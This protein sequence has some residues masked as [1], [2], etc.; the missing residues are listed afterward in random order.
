[1]FQRSSN[2]SDMVPAYRSANIIV[3]LDPALR[4][5]VKAEAKARSTSVRRVTM[6][7]VIRELIASH[8]IA[9]ASD[10]TPE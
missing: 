1:M 3:G 2:V 5:A 10:V 6:S 7:E 8:L 9:K 4:E